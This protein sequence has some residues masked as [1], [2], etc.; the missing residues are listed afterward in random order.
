MQPA[1]ALS[2][3]RMVSVARRP[4]HPPHVLALADASSEPPGEHARD[5][6]DLHGGQR[7]VAQRHPEQADTHVQPL[8]E[9]SAAAAVVNPPS[10]KRFFH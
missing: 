1:E 2:G 3:L 8:V 9:A 4:I 6:G 5:G 10:K 7:R